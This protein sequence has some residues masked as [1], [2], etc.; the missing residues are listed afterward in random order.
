MDTNTDFESKVSVAFIPHF[1]LRKGNGF[2][3]ALQTD[4]SVGGE[5]WRSE[6]GE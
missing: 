2:D 3:P 4:F 1:H 6:A 5:A